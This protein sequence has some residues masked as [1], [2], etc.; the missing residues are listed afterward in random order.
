MGS[1]AAEALDAFYDPSSY[2]VHQTTC[3]ELGKLVKRS[4][5]LLPEIEAARPR[6]STGIKALCSLNEAIEK[7]K[8]VLQQCNEG[9]KLYL[10]Y[11]ADAIMSR[12][13]K[14]RKLLEQSLVQIQ[15]N[16][17]VLLAIEISQLVDD[18]RSATFSLDLPDEEAGRFVQQLLQP[19]A[20]DSSMVEN[21]E[22]NTFQHA[23][24]K[25]HITSPKAILIEKRSIRK[26]LIKTGDSNP[27]KKKIL[28][29]FFHLFK[30]YADQ[31]VVDQAETNNIEHAEQVSSDSTRYDPLP[32]QPARVEKRTGSS[33]SVSDPM[34]QEGFKCPLSLRIMYDPV[35][36]ASGQTF[37]RVWIQKWF[38]EGND[39][40]PK[41][42]MKLPNLLMTPNAAI[43]DLISRWCT[44]YGI[45][46]SDP[47][48]D[49]EREAVPTRDYS[50]T[51]IDS[52]GSS[53]SDLHLQVDLSSL[54]LG[55]LDTSFGSDASLSK[56]TSGLLRM[57]MLVNEN[58]RRKS[59]ESILRMSELPWKSQCDLVEDFRRRVEI[60]SQAFHLATLEN[61]VSPIVRFLGQAIDQGDV[62][63]QMTGSHLL[64]TYLKKS[65]SGAQ[66]MP[67]E[68]YFMLASLLNSSD[69]VKVEALATIEMLS[70]QPLCRSKIVSSGALPLISDV[71]SSRS[72]SLQGSALRVLQNLT[73]DRDIQPHV[74]SLDNIISK[75]VTFLTDNMLS[76]YVLVIL[77]N[78]CDIEAA[79]ISITKTS[80]CIASIAELLNSGNNDEKEI[81]L[82]IFLTLCSQKLEYCEL[83][84]DEGIIPALVLISVNGSQRSKGSALELLRLLRDVNTNESLEICCSNS[85]P[86]QKNYQDEEPREIRKSTSSRP[87]RLFGI[88]SRQK[89]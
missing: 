50:V 36:I 4:L 76:L 52:L 84:M 87:R 14:W 63:A 26:I 35:V 68:L 49:L 45:S 27:T 75:L 12:C 72:S 39:T 40:C 69:E 86:E 1:D 19:V 47:S 71:L 31:I 78:L 60:D 51:S 34:L 11:T 53:I 58:S 9:S 54:S 29:Y 23:L 70:S 88:F 13:E 30:Q 67:E 85:Y 33:D 2:K 18:I 22:L 81:S 46:I 5:S 56:L 37:E 8:I 42:K 61:F 83:V 10:V 16:V 80:G 79:R 25:L 3:G 6:C 77:Q 15:S 66:L 44:K 74:F 41:T 38:E 17:P 7:A 62:K 24:L 57:P 32:R 59:L 73:A 28:A 48:A 65:R 43:K 21:F 64:L 55:S 89:R 20:S 82:S